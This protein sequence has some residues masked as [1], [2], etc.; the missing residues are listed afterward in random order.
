MRDAGLNALPV[1]SNG[2]LWGLLRVSDEGETAA[3]AVSP[4]DTF[5]HVHIDEPLS[6]ALE[7]MGAETLDVLPVVSRANTRQMLGW[8]T[9]ADILTAFGLEKT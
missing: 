8:V 4:T 7:K 6:L 1:G 5:P 2:S 3:S 9:L